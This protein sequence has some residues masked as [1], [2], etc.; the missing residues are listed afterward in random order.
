MSTE[1]VRTYSTLH[2]KLIA[3]ATIPAL[4]WTVRGRTIVL[5]KLNVTHGILKLGA[6]KLLKTK[7]MGC[8]KTKTHEQSYSAPMK[9]T[10][11]KRMK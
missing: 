9:T 8:G 11:N 6:K 1:T 4:R 2:V 3:T 7:F 10:F 5:Q